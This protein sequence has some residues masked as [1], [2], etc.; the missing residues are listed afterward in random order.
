M[1]VQGAVLPYALG[2][3]YAIGDHKKK[4]APPRCPKKEIPKRKGLKQC[5]EVR[6]IFVYLK[7]LQIQLH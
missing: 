7:Y 2:Q 4:A 1:Q 5:T 3:M 6:F